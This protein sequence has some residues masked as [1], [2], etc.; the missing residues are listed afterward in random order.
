MSIKA[1]V[2]RHAKDGGRECQN[3]AEDQRT[4]IDLLN[5]IPAAAGGAGGGLKPRIV[6]GVCSDEL[7]RAILVFEG[8]YMPGPIDGFLDPDGGMLKRMEELTKPAGPVDFVAPGDAGGGFQ[9]FHYWEAPKFP[10]GPNKVVTGKELLIDSNELKF[11]GVAGDGAKA[12][13]SVTSTVPG[14]VVI[15]DGG[16]S[17]SV[18]WWRVSRPQKPGVVIQA[19][20]AKGAV[21]ASVPFNVVLMPG[22]SGDVELRPDPKNPKNLVSYDPEEDPDYIDNRMTGV[23]YEIYLKNGFVVYVSGLT[24]PINV[25]DPFTDLDEKSAQPIDAKVY[26]SYAEATD[27]VKAASAKLKGKKYFAYYRAA[28]GAVIAPTVFSPASAPRTIATLWVA[29]QMYADFVQKSL[30]GVAM[31]IVTGMVY[32]AAVGRLMRA[33]DEPEPPSYRPAQPKLPPAMTRLRNTVVEGPATP[34]RSA[35]VL[36]APKTYRHTLSGGGFYPSNYARIEAKGVL[37]VSSGGQDAQYGEGVYAWFAGKPTNQP[38]IDIE[39]PPGTG[40]ETLDFGGGKGWVR[41]VPP[42]GED[43]NVKIVGTNLSSD[44]IAAGR[45]LVGNDLGDDD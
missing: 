26:K 2:G 30:A 9:Y 20:D 18:H 38:Y 31:N 13:A 8:R 39:V 7:Y 28:G 3:W 37:T 42:S 40:V 19:K 16:V 15:E 35:E 14:A 27:A 1:R 17:G 21:L 5:A 23:G 33:S 43:L 36:T 24:T 44:E 32:R 25:S 41:M 29:R 4:V 6:S 34:V 12:V 45:K 10:S 22:G 11:L